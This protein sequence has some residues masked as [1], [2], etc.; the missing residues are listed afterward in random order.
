MSHGRTSSRTTRNPPLESSPLV[1]KEDPTRECY[2]FLPR[3]TSLSDTTAQLF[4]SVEQKKKEKREKELLI[5]ST[6]GI[7]DP[8]FDSSSSWTHDGSDRPLLRRKIE[9]GHW[10]IREI[11]DVTISSTF[12]FRGGKPE[13]TGALARVDSATCVGKRARFSLR[14]IMAMD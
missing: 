6:T 12:A 8:I 14:S 2:R 7:S 13:I 1:K 4:V 9:R 11:S 3:V 10:I 5:P